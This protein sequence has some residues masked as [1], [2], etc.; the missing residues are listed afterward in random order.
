MEGA[1]NQA[2]TRAPAGAVFRRVIAESWLL[3]AYQLLEI[4][5]VDNYRQVDEM[6][7]PDPNGPRKLLNPGD[8][9]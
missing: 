5:R 1:S 6:S 8:Y 7:R 9:G 3:V 2:N 4:G